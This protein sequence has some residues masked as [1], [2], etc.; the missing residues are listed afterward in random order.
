MPLPVR[1]IVSLDH[2]SR[3]ESFDPERNKS[4]LGLAEDPAANRRQQAARDA[5]RLTLSSGDAVRN[6]RRTKGVR[7]K[8]L[9]AKSAI[10]TR[11]AR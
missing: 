11:T 4:V 6:F 5:W 7:D 9:W 1:Q 2:L 3:F 8:V 10:C